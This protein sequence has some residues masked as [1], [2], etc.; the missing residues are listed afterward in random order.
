MGR[1]KGGGGKPG[2]TEGVP[3][4]TGGGGSSGSDRPVARMLAGQ[5]EG[6]DSFKGKRGV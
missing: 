6:E 5:E 1:R 2:D 4:G 3:L